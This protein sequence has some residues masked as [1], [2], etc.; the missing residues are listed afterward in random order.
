MSPS[1]VSSPGADHT[2]CTTL[3][4]PVDPGRNS[5]HYAIYN[6][7]LCVKSVHSTKPGP[8]FGSSDTEEF[9][10][11]VRIVPPAA[12]HISETRNQHCILTFS[13]FPADQL[14][15]HVSSSSTHWSIHTD[16]ISAGPLRGILFGGTKCILDPL[17]SPLGHNFKQSM[18][19]NNF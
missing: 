8:Q 14:L 7:V 10:G 16:V 2:T 6:P 19:H 17:P 3:M 11:V 5:S 1:L 15:L 13:Q 9:P 4:T 12:S 18:D